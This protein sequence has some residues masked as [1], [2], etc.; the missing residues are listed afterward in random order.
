MKIFAG[1]DIHSKSCTYAVLSEDGQ[2]LSRGSFETTPEAIAG[3]AKEQK[4]GKESRIGMESGGMT[5]FVAQQLLKLE[6]DVV[7]IHANEVRK[8][9]RSKGKKSDSRD[10][11]EIADGLR[12][13]SY[14]QIV[15]LPDSFSQR[16]R[17]RIHMRRHFVR[18]ASKEVTTVKCRLRA[19]GLGFVYK[20]LTTRKAFDKL[21]ARPEIDE[22]VREQI[23]MHYAVWQT[24]KAQQKQVDAQIEKMAAEQPKQMELLKS[25]PGV[26]AV[27]GATVIAYF[28]KPE[29]FAT[30]KHAA[31]YCGLTTQ[32]YHSGEGADRYGHITKEGPKE[33]RSMLCEAAQQARRKTN[34]FHAMYNRIKAKKGYKIA[35]IAVAHRLARI[36]WAVL[37]HEKLFDATKLHSAA[38]NRLQQ[39]SAT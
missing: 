5:T 8:K 32:T 36:C 35:V 20:T 15:R 18:I 4:L 7:V 12:R 13:D 31:S 9:A 33:L 37:R 29:R 28:H 39:A 25:V 17:D 11:F 16:L 24:A 26:G 38:W 34:P 30:A 10:A 1:L 3:W 23:R 21:L 27:V 14:V 2:V 6:L 22:A 19:L